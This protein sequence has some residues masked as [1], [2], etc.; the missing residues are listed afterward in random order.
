MQKNKSESQKHTDPMIQDIPQSNEKEIE[1]KAEKEGLFKGPLAWM[2]RNHV[3]ANL[4]MFTMILGGIIMVGSLRQELMPNVE[5]ERI[6]VSASY[7]GSS[8]DEVEEGI[9]IAIEEAV[10]GINGVKKTTSTASEGSGRVVIELLDGADVMR[11]RNEIVS[12]QR[13]LRFKNLSINLIKH[14]PAQIICSIA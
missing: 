8:P 6:Q 11:T 2:A 10:R 3:A 4:L 14:I 13:I 1:E 5:A 12:N 9:V 7:P